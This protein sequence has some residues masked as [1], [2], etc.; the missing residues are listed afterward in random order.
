V[1]RIAYWLGF[2]VGVGVMTDL[3]YPNPWLLRWIK[4][5]ANKEA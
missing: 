2:V 4:P 5:D 1:K 3:S